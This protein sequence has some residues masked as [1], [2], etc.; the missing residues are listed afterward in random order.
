MA[1]ILSLVKL[2]TTKTHNICTYTRIYHNIM[3][4]TTNVLQYTPDYILY[5]LII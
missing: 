2:G 5:F 3:T 4:G 1:T